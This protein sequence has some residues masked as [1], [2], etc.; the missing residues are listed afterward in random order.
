MATCVVPCA[1]IQIQPCHCVCTHI[2]LNTFVLHVSLGIHCWIDLLSP[3]IL[4]FADGMCKPPPCLCA[5]FFVPLLPLYRQTGKQ[6]I[7]LWTHYSAWSSYHNQPSRVSNL[8]SAK[9][10]SVYNVA[11]VS[12][13]LCAFFFLFPVQERRKGKSKE[14]WERKTERESRRGKE[15]QRKGLSAHICTP[16][17]GDIPPIWNKMSLWEGQYAGNTVNNS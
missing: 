7:I 17:S 3:I 14:K 13:L 5:S 4:C 6:M 9:L 1:F 12:V 8:G 11:F 15:G 10:C 2:C 16:V